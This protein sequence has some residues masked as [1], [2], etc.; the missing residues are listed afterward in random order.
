M[1]DSI[2][3]GVTTSF[4][5]VGIPEKAFLTKLRC[6]ENAALDANKRKSA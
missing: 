2:S 4:T 3:A 5:K 1:E 6:L